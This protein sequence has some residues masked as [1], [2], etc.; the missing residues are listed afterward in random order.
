RSACIDGIATLTMKKSR[1]IIAVPASRT[2]S[3]AHL[4]SQLA[5]TAATSRA[6][7]ARTVGLAVL[8]LRAPRRGHGALWGLPQRESQGGFRGALRPKIATTRSKAVRA[9]RGAAKGPQATR[10]GAPRP[11]PKRPPSGML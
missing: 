1:T 2:G 3:A 10:T 8:M 4:A 6:A 5:R 7:D 9:G 11:W